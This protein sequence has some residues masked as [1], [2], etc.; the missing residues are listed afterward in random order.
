[1]TDFTLLVTI[2]E[3]HADKFAVMVSVAPAGDW[4]SSSELEEGIATSRPDALALCTR[5]VGSATDRV[6][7][8]GDSV[9]DVEGPHWI[10]L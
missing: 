7:A 9:V 10:P 3:V 5:L 2:A 6:M 1:M 8:R 4:A